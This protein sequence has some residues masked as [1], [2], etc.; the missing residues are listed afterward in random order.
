MT[1][2]D[3]VRDIASAADIS[4]KESGAV[5]TALLE[6]LYVALENGEK[7][8]HTGF[9]TFDTKVSAERVGVNPFTKKKI[10]YP[11]KRKMS[12]KAAKL[13][14]DTLNEE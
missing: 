4:R 12:F 14:K 8:T 3:L 7:Y 10:K 5:L 11:Q 9:G 1:R 13:L 2:Q 6:E